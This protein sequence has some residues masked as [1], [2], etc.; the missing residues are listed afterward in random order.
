LGLDYAL[1]MLTVATEEYPPVKLKDLE[2]P[3]W[4]ISHGLKKFGALPVEVDQ[5]PFLKVEV[6]PLRVVAKGGA[7]LQHHPGEG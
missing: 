7:S 1:Y 6:F 2:K 4:V 5:L 3:E